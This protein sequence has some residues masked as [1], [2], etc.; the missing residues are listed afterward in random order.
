MRIVVNDVAASKGG[1]MTVLRDFYNS[2]RE[3]DTE[4]EWIFLLGD[5]YL[6]E[7][8]NIKVIALPSVKSSQLKR[9]CFD[10][11]TGKR[12]ISGLKPDVVFSMQNTVT[13]GLNI[14]QVIYMHQSIP[15]QDVKSFSFFK[16]GERKLWVIQHLLGSIIRMS[17]R[18]ANKVIVQTEWIRD[19]VIKK[20]G[21][22]A[23]KVVNIFPPIKDTSV[24]FDTDAFDRTSFYY[25][26]AD[27]IYKNNGAIYKASEIL[28]G[29]GVPHSIKL[30]LSPEK[31]TDKIEC[32][33][34]MPYS[35]VLAQ[36]AKSTLVFP[37]YIETVGYPMLEARA[38]GT[39]I[40]ASDC[41]FSREV[42]KG[43]ENAYFF[44]PFKPEQLAKL[45][46]KV[47]CGEIERK[48]TASASINSRDTWTDVA[49]EIIK[50]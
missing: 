43:Y 5:K 19:A 2:V 29:E 32:V 50:L 31:G 17:V 1:A 46:K 30:T 49:K 4:N 9:L 41:P 3:N 24:L 10:F 25:P 42:L 40:I 21:V 20:C 7:T 15:F 18:R 22:D 33:G 12:F 45:M 14:P 48:E 26:T 28:C 23:S 37:S 36:Y 44:D 39:L 27:M 13:F 38:V 47:A 35:D 16:S 34:R 11:F 6:E 8:E